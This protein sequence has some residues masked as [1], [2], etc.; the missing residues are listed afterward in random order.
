MNSF[1]NN[2]IEASFT[3]N[4]RSD[5]T[6]AARL[7]VSVNRFGAYSIPLISSRR[8]PALTDIDASLTSN[9]WRT[10][11]SPM[12]LPFNEYCFAITPEIPSSKI[13]FSSR[14]KLEVTS[15]LS[16]RPNEIQKIEMLCLL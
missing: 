13:S 4:Y 15:F 7:K 16:I 2:D 10:M 3:G 12:P 5:I 6:F 1:G 11:E 8:V 9:S 14:A